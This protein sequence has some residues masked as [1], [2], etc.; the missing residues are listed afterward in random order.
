MVD[1]GNG[2]TI[3]LREDQAPPLIASYDKRNDPL[4]GR[5]LTTPKSQRNERPRL[6]VAVHGCGRWTRTAIR[7]DLIKLKSFWDEE[8]KDPEK[9]PPLLTV[10]YVCIETSAPFGDGKLL[11]NSGSPVEETV[12]DTEFEEYFCEVVA[13]DIERIGGREYALVFV[14]TPDFAHGASIKFW[15][16][17]VGNGIGAI[18]VEKPFT[19]SS[20]EAKAIAATLQAHEATNSG[21]APK[22][23][24]LDHY[25][26][27][28][29]PLHDLGAIA[30]DFGEPAQVIFHMTEKGPIE[31][32]RLPSLQNGMAF[33]MFSH[34]LGLLDLFFKIAE[35]GR[36]ELHSAGRHRFARF[37]ELRD[38]RYFAETYG[39][40]SFD[41]PF[42]SNNGERWVSCYAR[43]GKALEKESKFIEIH[44]VDGKVLRMD[45]TSI[46]EDSPAYRY[47]FRELML[48]SDSCPS[49]VKPASG[50]Q[51]GM[52]DPNTAESEVGARVQEVAAA[53]MIKHD[54]GD[55]WFVDH[56]NPGR[57]IEI[58]QRVRNDYDTVCS[59]HGILVEA[60]A[61]NNP[62][63]FR[64]TLSLQSATDIV[65]ALENL[66]SEIVELPTH[67]PGWSPWVPPR[68]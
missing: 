44:D 39:E 11:D 55:D 14:A 3:D 8:A 46:Q 19:T 24:A 54:P 63:A 15:L 13:R 4:A 51:L 35:I 53:T 28:G 41:V 36:F 65:T 12:I 68:H 7:P 25:L 45:L 32:D 66:R 43:F 20:H 21:P 18:L 42:R 57:M 27:Y 49:G 58:S 10:T 9:N 67:H 16:K 56:H 64:A 23:L 29:L 40:V 38:R 62:R 47:P 34:C 50:F 33:D 1:V 37:K 5:S 30:S 52:R 60:L 22:V 6:N 2:E 26:L 59:R 31:A 48:Y 61:N 17:N